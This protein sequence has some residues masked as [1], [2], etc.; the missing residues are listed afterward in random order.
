MNDVY[1]V[2]ECDTVH[3]DLFNNICRKSNNKKMTS[4]EVVFLYEFD[5]EYMNNIMTC[6]NL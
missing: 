4:P 3:V 2:Y 6:S 5:Y 1:I